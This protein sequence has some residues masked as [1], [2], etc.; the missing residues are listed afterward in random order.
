VDTQRQQHRIF[1]EEKQ[2]LIHLQ[3]QQQMK[4]NSDTSSSTLKSLPF[5]NTPLSIKKSNLTQERIQL[6]EKEG[7]IWD[8][9]A[10]KWEERYQ[11]LVQYKQTH[12]T[13][14]VPKVDQYEILYNWVF[15]QRRQYKFKLSGLDHSSLTQERI[16]KLDALGF[17]WNYQDE[18]WNLQFQQLQK[19]RR[20]HGHCLI[21][22]TYFNRPLAKWVEVQRM[23]YRNIHKQRLKQLTME[24]EEEEDD[25][26]SNSAE[27]TSPQDCVAYSPLTETRIQLLDNEE[28]VWD[29]AEY[30]WNIHFHQLKEFSK[31]NGHT[32]VPTTSL[33]RWCQK[34][35]IEYKKKI[36]G[37]KTTMTDSRRDRLIQVG[38]LFEIKNN[39]L[40]SMGS[41]RRK[42]RKKPK[43]QSLG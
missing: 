34:Q 21:P 38:F 26:P 14:I 36:Q 28:F 11:D 12:G 1:F 7:F 8:V 17:I 22:S 24:D 25:R 13:V 39:D 3:Q 20:D 41:D 9:H 18:V 31:I 37:E 16:D 32:F 2:H 10:L 30:Q 19:F 40:P 23:H 43:V 5:R 4:Q 33:G 15:T 35:R 29:V 27:D 42:Y 6:L